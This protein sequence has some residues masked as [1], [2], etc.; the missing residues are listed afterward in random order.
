MD[1]W[2]M[3]L[4]MAAVTFGVRYPVLAIFSRAPLPPA[5]IQALRFV[6][7]AV[8][9]AIIAPA[10]LMPAGTLD[11]SPSNAWLVGGLVCVVVA[12]RTRKLLPTIVIGMAVFLLWRAAF[13]V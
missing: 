10:L 11:L 4:G 13:G 2:V 1:V 3:I 8:L 9:T 6:P 12:A 5:V 7:V